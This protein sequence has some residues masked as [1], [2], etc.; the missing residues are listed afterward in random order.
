MTYLYSNEI[1]GLFYLFTSPWW[2][3]VY[4]SNIAWP[5][6]YLH[7]MTYSVLL[8]SLVDLCC[9]WLIFLMA[10]SVHFPPVDLYST[11][12]TSSWSNLYTS[13]FYGQFYLLLLGRIFFTYFLATCARTSGDLCCTHTSSWWPI[14]FT[15][16]FLKAYSLLPPVW[17]NLY[18]SLF[19][20]RGF[21]RPT[22]LYLTDIY[23]LHVPLVTYSVQKGLFDGLF[24]T[25]NAPCWSK[26]SSWPSLYTSDFMAYISIFTSPWWAYLY[27]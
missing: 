8:P 25:Q 16:K 2:A 13:D 4:I 17:F 12:T 14:L 7:L 21:L 20:H 15:R 9:V 11:R 10:Y 22:L 1:Y 5:H 19:V 3:Y 26:F 24:C 6:D 23:Y 27:I 18:T